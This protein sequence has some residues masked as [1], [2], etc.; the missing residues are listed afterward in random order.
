MVK[1]NTAKSIEEAIQIIEGGQDA[2]LDVHRHE[3]AILEI[4]DMARMFPKK[5]C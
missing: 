4:I 5:C 2:V 1:V 3:P